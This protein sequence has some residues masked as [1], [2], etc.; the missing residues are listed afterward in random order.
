MKRAW[1]LVA[2]LVLSSPVWATDVNLD[3]AKWSVGVL[4]NEDEIGTLLGYKAGKYTTVGIDGRWYDSLGDTDTEAYSLSAYVAWNA[5][6]EM[7]IPI[8]GLFP[9]VDLPLPESIRCAIN[10]GG[11]IG[12]I[13]PQ[14]DKGY[15]FKDRDALVKVFA[16]A[17]F[18]LSE[19]ATL[20][21]RYEYAFD[22]D[23]W[24]KLTDAVPQHAAFLTLKYTF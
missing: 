9:Q 6:P 13:W 17:E 1:I 19:P 8:G 20:G 21:L 23:R 16:E 22:S 15:D 24:G 18:P 10:L 7:N 3:P 14:G 2:L 12:A 5:V 11:S 4:G